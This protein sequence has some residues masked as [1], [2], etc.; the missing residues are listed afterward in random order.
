MKITEADAVMI[1]NLN[2]AA[3]YVSVLNSPFEMDEGGDYL[4]YCLSRHAYVKDITN[5][6]FSVGTFP[7][8]F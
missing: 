1:I 8:N 7:G 2:T 5:N 6:R 3:A 4:Q